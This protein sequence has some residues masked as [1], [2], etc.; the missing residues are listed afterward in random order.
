[1]TGLLVIAMRGQGLPEISPKTLYEQAGTNFP[2]KYRRGTAA[3]APRFPRQESG[4]HR[5]RAMPDDLMLNGRRHRAVLADEFDAFM[6]LAG[7]VRRQRGG[8]GHA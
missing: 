4:R 1:M 2:R 8:E 3:A 6:T 7:S 5:R